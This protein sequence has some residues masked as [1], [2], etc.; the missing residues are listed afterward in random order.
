MDEADC[1]RAVFR[2]AS[3]ER[4]SLRQA[5]LLESDFSQANLSGARATDA[6]F[7]RAVLQ[8]ADCSSI[9]VEAAIFAGVVGNPAKQ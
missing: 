6:M 8:G 2:K 7:V 4:V 1:S 5:Q 9:D 3:L